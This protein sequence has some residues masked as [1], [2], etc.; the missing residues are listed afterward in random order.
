[1]MRLSLGGLPAGWGTARWLGWPAA[2]PATEP[3]QRTTHPQAATIGGSPTTHRDATPTVAAIS[4][5]LLLGCPARGSC[6][7][8]GPRQDGRNEPVPDAG[9]S[10]L[11]SH[12]AKD[13]FFHL[14]SRSIGRRE[15]RGQGHGLGASLCQLPSLGPATTTQLEPRMWSSRGVWY[16]HRRP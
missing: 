2:N 5:V 1:M 10:S 9:L 13:R 6:Y 16:H 11:R 12:M 8:G 7:P 3:S 15:S 14:C 4:A